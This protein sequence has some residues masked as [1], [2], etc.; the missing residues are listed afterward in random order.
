MFTNILVPLDGSELA[1]GVLPYVRS[2]VRRLNSS[3]ELLTV[4]EPEN[5]SAYTDPEHGRYFDNV[6][7]GLRQNA[8]TYLKKI[9]AS[10]TAE[11]KVSY[12]IEIANPANAILERAPDPNILIAMSTHGQTGIKR[13]LLGSVAVKM[14]HASANPLLLVRPNKQPKNLGEASL[15]TIVVPLDGSALAE[16][17]LPTAAT[18][19]K[20]MDLE[21]VLLRV[22]SVPSAVPY[23]DEAFMYD[24]N[25]ARERFKSEAKDYLTEKQKELQNDGVKHVAV[26]VLEGDASSQIIAYARKTPDNFIA[27]STHGLSGIGRWFLGSVTDR[28]VCHSGDPVLVIRASS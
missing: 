24:F 21:I 12:A 13:W 28:V 1:E 14:L 4:I 16:K 8:E 27:M 23:A 26:L 18:L 17:A 25:A 7:A 9:A 6:E 2:L 11:S 22:Y 15:K 5:V 19:A 20:R 10:L 3:V